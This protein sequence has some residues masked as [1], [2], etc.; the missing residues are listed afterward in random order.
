MARARLSFRQR[1]VARAIKAVRSTGERVAGVRIDRDG[2][3]TVLIG[4]GAGAAS[5][6]TPNSNPWDAAIVEVAGGART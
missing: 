1:D 3:I 6:D 2:Q 4:D 5:S